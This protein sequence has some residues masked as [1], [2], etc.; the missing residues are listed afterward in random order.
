[1]YLLIVDWLFYMDND[2]N[3]SMDNSLCE[4]L[5][6]TDFTALTCL[7]KVQIPQD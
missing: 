4:A 7:L 3:S 2:I 6:M 1:M 5:I